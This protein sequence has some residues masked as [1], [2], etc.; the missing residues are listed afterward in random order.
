MR[1]CYF[2]HTSDD[3]STQSL[4]CDDTRASAL[5]VLLRC[6]SRRHIMNTND[7]T[8]MFILYDERRTCWIQMELIRLFWEA[9]IH[10]KCF[11]SRVEEKNVYSLHTWCKCVNT[12]FIAQTL[13]FQDSGGSWQCY[14]WIIHIWLKHY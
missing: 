14:L 9:K 7:P 6:A 12:D 3:E 11:Q 13:L 1:T 2:S 4:L 10:K 8:T 5:N